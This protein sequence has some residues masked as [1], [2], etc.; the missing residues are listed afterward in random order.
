MLLATAP[1]RALCDETIAELAGVEHFLV[2]IWVD[3]LSSLLYRDEAANNGVRVRHLL[4]YDFFL[5][6]R[7]SYQVNVRDADVQL[8]I[9]CLKVMTT[10]LRFNICKLDDSR[11]ANADVRDLPS[12]VEQYISGALQY[13]CLHWLDHLCFPPANRDQR[14]LVL[15][16]LK[17]FFEGLYPL[18]WVEVLSIMG[19]VPIGVPSLRRLLSWVRVSTLSC[20]YFGFLNDSTSLQDEDS[21]V[22]EIIR[23]ICHFLNIFHTPVSF[24]TPHIYISTRPFLPSRSPLSR[25]FDRNLPSWPAPPLEWVGHAGRVRSVGYSPNG[26]RVVTGS[27][28]RTIRIWDAG[29]GVVV[30]EPLT[31]H[32]AGVNSVAYSPNGRHIISG[33]LDNTIRVWDAKTGAAV[34]GPLRGHTLY[35]LSVAYSPDG[36]HIISGSSDRTI[37]IWDANTGAAVGDPLKGHTDSVTSVVYSP[38]GRHIISGSRD[39]TIR[40]WDAKTG[41]SVGDP[42]DPDGRHII[43]GSHDHTIRIWD[44]MTGA[45]AGGPLKGHTSWVASVAYSPDGR[46]IISGSSDHTIRVWD[47]KTGAAVG[48]PLEGHTHMVASVAYS[49]DGH[50]IISGSSDCTIRTWDA[51]AGNTDGKALEGPTHSVQSIP[52]SPDGQHIV[53]GSCDHITR[54]WDVFPSASIRPSSCCCPI[55]PELFAKPDGEGWVRDSEGGLLYWVP[56]ECRSSVHSSALMTIPVISHYRSVSFDFDNIAFGTSWTRILK[57]APS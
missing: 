24:S 56:H 9:A 33:S 54:V 13:S 25:M 31:G 45:A 3:A 29:S 14:M 38:D 42:L 16:S 6:D 8:G 40:I 21:T 51:E 12:R 20:Y 46:H 22:L 47:A 35:V 44:A 4:V 32:Y 55:H 52:Y 10:Q 17:E 26:T 5:S 57:S 7:G 27:D 11:L 43:S 15:E 41:A 28:D 18:F 23:D 30:G 34:G 37:R 36:R 1:Y 39:H 49:P 53:C 19:M 2:K 50:H 48:D